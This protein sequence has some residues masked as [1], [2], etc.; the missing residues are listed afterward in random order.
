[1]RNPG[2]KQD[3]FIFNFELVKNSGIAFGIPFKNFLQVFIICLIFILTIVFFESDD[4]YVKINTLFVLLGALS[5]LWDRL[6]V[7]AVIDYIR[8]WP[9][10]LYFN[11]ADM[12]ITAGTLM[13][14]FK[15]V[16]REP[17]TNHIE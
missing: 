7:K 17:S 1:M 8:I 3:F 4:S 13:I 16:Q 5:N 12:M 11:I 14:I 15:L 10:N 9:I 6:I 2:F